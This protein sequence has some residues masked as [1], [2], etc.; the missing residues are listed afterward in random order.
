MDEEYVTSVYESCATVVEQ[1]QG[2]GDLTPEQE[3]YESLCEVI[4]YLYDE[5]YVSPSYVTC[6]T[7][8]GRVFH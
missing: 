1:L 3:G 5:L 6:G 4:I 8:K 7:N 2:E